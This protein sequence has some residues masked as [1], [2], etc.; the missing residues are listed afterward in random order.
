MGNFRQQLHLFR[1][2]A[3]VPE[4][5][6][7]GVASGLYLP[8]L[9]MQA[10]PFPFPIFPFPLVLPSLQLFSPLFLSF[11]SS[12][13]SQ[14]TALGRFPPFLALCLSFGWH[15]VSHSHNQCQQCPHWHPL[16]SLNLLVDVLP[17]SHPLSPFSSLS[18]HVNRSRVISGL[19][20]TITRAGIFFTEAL[21]PVSF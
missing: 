19:V 1:G 17:A 21:F 15:W 20:N 4:S 2:W 9:P 10:Y 8:P 5:R 13:S 3:Y 6:Q 12:L 11:F 18:P 16:G 14:F 7:L